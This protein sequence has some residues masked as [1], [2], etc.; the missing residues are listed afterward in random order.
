MKI[1]IL[2]ENSGPKAHFAEPERQCFDFSSSNFILLGHILSTVGAALRVL[3]FEEVLLSAST[4]LLRLSAR[5]S[6]STALCLS[7]FLR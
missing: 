5:P 7:F 1:I 4:I 3:L 6:L 2:W